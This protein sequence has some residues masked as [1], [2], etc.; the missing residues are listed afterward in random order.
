ME[1][2]NP[3]AEDGRTAQFVALGNHI[4]LVATP[5]PRAQDRGT[6]GRTWDAL[7]LSYEV[8]AEREQWLTTKK[9]LP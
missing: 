8:V 2:S 7:D 3:A 5:I 9:L 4:R 1:R 6:A